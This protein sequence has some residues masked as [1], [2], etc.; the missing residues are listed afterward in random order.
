MNLFSYIILEYM[1]IIKNTKIFKYIH[2][3]PVEI[4][5]MWAIIGITIIILIL[6]L[7]GKLTCKKSNMYDFILS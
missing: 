7:F 3:H 5:T 1:E 6:L 2:D 4:Y